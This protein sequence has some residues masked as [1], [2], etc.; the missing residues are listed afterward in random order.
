MQQDLVEKKEVLETFTEDYLKGVMT[1]YQNAMALIHVQKWGEAIQ[2][3]ES[4]AGPRE[5]Q[6]DAA[7]KVAILKKI[8]QSSIAS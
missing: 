4:M 8:G 3:F 5:L 1:T 2:A 7:R 6:E